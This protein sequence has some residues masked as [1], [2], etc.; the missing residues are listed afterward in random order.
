M[1]ENDLVPEVCDQNFDGWHDFAWPV[2]FG[3]VMLDSAAGLVDKSCRG[4][5]G[6]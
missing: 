5:S 6:R 1:M 3:T 2:T 4:Y